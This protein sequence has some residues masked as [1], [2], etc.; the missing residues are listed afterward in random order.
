PTSGDISYDGAN[1]NWLARAHFIEH[2]ATVMQDDTLLSGSIAE[3]IAFFDA[4][5]D[6]ER[7]EAAA[8]SAC[9]H[10]DIEAMPMRYASLI[11]DMGSALS[12][13]Q[14]QRI[15]IARA[16]YKRPKILFMDEGTSQLDVK[17]ERSINDN[18]SKLNITRVIVAHRPDTLRIADRVLNLTH[19]KLS[20]LSV[21]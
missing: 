2:I 7:I 14:K 21:T 13:G 11:G 5:L 1:I 18:I 4:P 17:V 20:E 10:A 19:G 6:F 3:N 16:L 9:I 15:M 8:K 12:G